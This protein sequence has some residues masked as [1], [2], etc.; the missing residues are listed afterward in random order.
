MRPTSEARKRAA[1]AMSLGAPMRRSSVPAAIVSSP[2]PL[3][4]PRIMRDRKGPGAMEL[5]VTL[6]A[7]LTARWRESMF[8]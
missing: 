5:T 8:T 6:G 2:E 1:P 4:V 7:R 3:K